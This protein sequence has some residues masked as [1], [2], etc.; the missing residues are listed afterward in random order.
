M[1]L[2]LSYDDAL[3][4]VF[5]RILAWEIKIAENQ[6]SVQ[7]LV[8]NQVQAARKE[9]G[10]SKIAGGAPYVVIQDLRKTNPPL[11]TEK[12]TPPRPLDENWF[13]HKAWRVLNIPPHNAVRQLSYKPIYKLVLPDSSKQTY[14]ELLVTLRNPAMPKLRVYLGKDMPK[15]QSFEKKRGVYF[16]RVTQG[17]YIGK[18]SELGTR[19][20]EH[21]R[22]KNPKWWVFISPEGIE[23]TFA[24]DTLEATESLLISFWNE[25][26]KVSNDKRGSD[27]E[28][29]LA[30]L[31][32]AV[33]LVESA[34]SVLLWLIREKSKLEKELSDFQ[35]EDWNIPFKECSGKGWP[36]CYL[37]VAQE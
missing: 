36:D 8:D 16:L 32:E 37:S 31:Q 1:S 30:Y 24:L 27:Q 35:L 13:D 34:S 21:F 6:P 33:L 9:L 5:L 12:N 25:V 26:S 10:L 14:K 18:T 19:L 4:A 23:Q 2:S 3:T 15:I 20:V 17:L 29:A 7:E 28:P 11:L 22:K